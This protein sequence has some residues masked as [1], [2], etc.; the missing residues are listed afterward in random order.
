M[1]L[2]ELEWMSFL[3]DNGMVIAKP[4]RSLEVRDGNVHAYFEY[5]EG[6]QVDVTNIHHWNEAN[7]RQLGRMI[8]KMHSLSK[9]F[10]L[11]VNHRP[12]W[13][14]DT[15]DVY[16]IRKNLEPL[17]IERY[18]EWMK[19]LSSYLPT[20]DTFGFIHNDFHQG[21][22]LVREGILTII[23]FD[24]CS[25]NWFAQDLAVLFYHAYWQNGSFT[26]DD[27]EQFVHTFMSQVFAGY[28]EENKL[29]AV[30]VKQ[31]PIFLKLREI[32]LFQLFTKEW[33]L[34]QLQDWLKYTIHDLKVKISSEEPY[35]GI[36]DFG[37]F[38]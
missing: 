21:N 33:D 29:D 35:G 24:E 26:N 5:I 37:I 38:V 30:I 28:Q 16:G 11:A 15:P 18:D 22:I 4:M 34:E 36:Y 27:K 2:Q 13:T 19:H 1:V 17:V 20:I 6:E 25:F 23:D 3:S 8:G 10:K 31:I 7:F 14:C 32:F 12:V 9:E